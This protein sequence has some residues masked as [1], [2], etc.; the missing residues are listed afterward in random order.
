[1]HYIWKSIAI[2]LVGSA[3]LLSVAFGLALPFNFIM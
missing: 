2:V 1:M 3:I